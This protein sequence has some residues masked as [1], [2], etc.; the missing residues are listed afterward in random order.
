MDGHVPL[1]MQAYSLHYMVTSTITHTRTPS[2][3]EDFILKDFSC[4]CALVHQIQLGKDTDGTYTC[5]L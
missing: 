3:R 4:I 5:V 1:D 2:E